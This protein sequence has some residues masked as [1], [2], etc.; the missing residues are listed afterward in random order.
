M[1]SWLAKQHVTTVSLQIYPMMQGAS[2]KKLSGTT[3]H[4]KDA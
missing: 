1:M 3:A 4:V 2:A